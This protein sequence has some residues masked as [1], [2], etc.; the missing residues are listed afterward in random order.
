MKL[1]VRVSEEQ[2]NNG[3]AEAA[4]PPAIVVAI[5][6]LRLVFIIQYFRRYAILVLRIKIIK[7]ED[8]KVRRI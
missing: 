3:N 4:S 1:T 8:L 7:I 5:N 2:D 6:F